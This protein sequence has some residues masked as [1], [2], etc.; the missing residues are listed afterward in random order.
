[1][2]KSVTKRLGKTIKVKFTLKSL[3]PPYKIKKLVFKNKL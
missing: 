3:Y 1:M 2:D